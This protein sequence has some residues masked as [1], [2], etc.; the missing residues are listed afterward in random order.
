MRLNKI[1]ILT[2]I[3]VLNFFTLL[4][5]G[6]NKP[7]TISGTAINF[8]N[9]IQVVNFSDAANFLLPDLERTFVPDSAGKFSI[10]FT[11]DKPGYFRMGRNVLFLSPG[12]SLDVYID[13]R[14]AEKADFK[15]RGAEA[16]AYLK[17][18]TFPKGGSFL[19]AGDEIK[20]DYE[21]TVQNV[22]AIAKQREQDL[23]N[24]KNIT[25]QFR[26][27]EAGRIKADLINSLWYIRIYYEDV[28][29]GDTAR[30]FKEE[31]D[32]K[33]IALIKEYSFDFYNAELL[34]IEVYRNILD[35]IE[36]DSPKVSGKV[37][38]QKRIRDWIYADEVATRLKRSS[39]KDSIRVL[40]KVIDKVATSSYR[41]LL[42]N[43]YSKQMAFG[44]G[45]VAKNFMAYSKSNEKVSLNQYKGSVICLDVWATWCGPCITEMPYFDKLKQ[46]Y[47]DNHNIVF[48]SLSI[49]SDKKGWKEYLESQNATG[50]QWIIDRLKLGDYSVLY[51]PRTIIIDR[52]FK[53][54]DMY[55]PRPSSKKTEEL[56]ETLLQ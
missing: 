11:V 56:I 50:N 30:L 8:N 12:D 2:G 10:S 40:L 53:V 1:I 4:A 17:Y 3:G 5:Q 29:K 47:K 38:D 14:F 42:K 39:N 41:S 25:G 23:I 45:D 49:D 44:N 54:F 33:A 7:V 32:K 31:Y 27:F 13:Y 9:Q 48:I 28:V 36:R 52:N 16:N 43:I 37:N 26:T 35:I 55:G 51:V 34:N 46:K 19:R 20:N 15:G 21:G 24:C 6:K 18:T 22:L